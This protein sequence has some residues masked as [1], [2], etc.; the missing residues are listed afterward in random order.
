MHS[1]A[2]QSD[3]DESTNEKM[4]Q[5]SARK[6]RCSDHWAS[7]HVKSHPN[8][9]APPEIC[10]RLYAGKTIP[11]ELYQPRGFVASG[12][13]PLVYP[14]QRLDGLALRCQFTNERDDA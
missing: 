4:A 1:A 5:L 7:P 13:P 6:E 12:A 2:P 10:Q 14:V 8:L 3:A 11:P 9:A